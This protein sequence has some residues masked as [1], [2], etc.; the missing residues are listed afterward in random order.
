MKRYK[1]WMAALLTGILVVTGTMSPA[2]AAEL[3]TEAEE[4]VSAAELSDELV[5]N[6]A[7]IPDVSEI[8][9]D[10]VAADIPEDDAAIPTAPDLTAE[11]PDEADT[12]SATPAF[13]VNS[14]TLS[15][16]TFLYFVSD[17]PSFRRS[18]WD[19][20]DDYINDSV[21]LILR[22]TLA[23]EEFDDVWITYTETNPTGDYA[24][25]VNFVLD[26]QQKD[27]NGLW[28]LTLCLFDYD[29]EIK[30]SGN[31]RLTSVLVEY[32]GE[33]YEYKTNS[34]LAPFRNCLDTFYV[35]TLQE[36]LDVLPAGTVASFSYLKNYDGGSIS[37]PEGI[38]VG[39]GTISKCATPIYV[40]GT[41]Y[42]SFGTDGC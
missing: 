37:I 32:D 9:E 19:E 10:E 25:T 24:H 15:N 7:A 34:E 1:K 36:F 14:M 27:Q 22:T 30:S 6:A 39:A 28:T 11:Q 16:D 29:D 2:L 40:N 31:Y 26:E 13:P 33:E 35:K 12:V 5:T 3:P 4:L 23:A 21:N 8:E 42:G 17:D 20:N 18:Y 38:T 41:I